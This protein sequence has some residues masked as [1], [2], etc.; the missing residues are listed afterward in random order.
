MENEP[1]VYGYGWMPAVGG[2]VVPSTVLRFWE[3]LRE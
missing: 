3:V 1:W 2:E